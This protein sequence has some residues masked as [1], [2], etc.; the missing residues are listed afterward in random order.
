MEFK[1]LLW[2]F[3]HKAARKLT[4]KIIGRV[5]KNNLQP[6]KEICSV[7]II[8]YNRINWKFRWFY[9]TLNSHAFNKIK[10][11]SAHQWNE[12][13]LRMAIKGSF[14]ELCTLLQE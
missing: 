8:S 5:M 3:S 7:R 10:L 12:A 9:I 6:E 14:E 4:A 2:N 1:E 11:T 13:V